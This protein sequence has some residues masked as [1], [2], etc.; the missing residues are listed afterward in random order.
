[1]ENE[2][3]IDISDLLTPPEKHELNTARYFSEMG[4]KIKFI[5]PSNIPEVYRPD[6]TMDGIEWEMKSPEGKRPARL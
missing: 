4:K 5:R 3:N 6:F 2:R 1:M